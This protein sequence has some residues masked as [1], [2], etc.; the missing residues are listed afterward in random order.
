MNGAAKYPPLLSG[1]NIFK[2]FSRVPVLHGVSFDLTEGEVHALA[3][4]NGAGKTTLIKIISGIYSDYQGTVRVKGENVRFRSPQEAARRG[5]AAIHQE[6][7]LVNSLS[8]LDNIFLGQEIRKAHGFIDFRKQ[9][10]QARLL[11]QNFG[12]D[13]DLKQPVGTFP[14]TTRQMIAL[15]KVLVSE[16]RI[17]AMDEPTSTLTHSEAEKLFEVVKA[18]KAKGCGI[19]YI[20]HRLEEIYALSDRVT[21]LRDGRRVGSFRTGELPSSELIRLMVG[22]EINQQFPPYFPGGG[23]ELLRLERVYVPDPSGTKGWAVEDVSFSLREGEILGFAGLQGSGKSELFHALFGSF[24]PKL[25]G[26]VYL[27]GK[28]FVSRSPLEA[29]KKGLVLLTNDRL[30]TGL[31]PLLG[32]VPNMTLA[33]LEKFSPRGWLN[34]NKERRVTEEYIEKLRI[35]VADL[36]QEVGTLSG[37]NQQ[38]VVLAKWLITQPRVVLLDEPTFGIDVGAKHEVYCL[39]ND[40]KKRGMAI[41][42]IASELPE[43]LALAD[44]I[45]VL[46]R[47]RLAASFSR[48]E[49]T[50]EKVMQAALGGASG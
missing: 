13:L 15:A 2:S 32:V 3:G 30:A 1:E 11:L 4:E 33:S 45:L 50:P 37:G 36:N 18:L 10:R 35:K 20:S 28:L 8:V 12:L 43:L 21:I 23:R 16:A 24:G 9:R 31:I 25:R 19:I 22:R 47:G 44:R 34:K 39:L 5:I 48:S 49:A 38:K 46:H 26:E 6:L 40:W 27:D 7:S 14:Y 41:A 42:L 29:I 17:I